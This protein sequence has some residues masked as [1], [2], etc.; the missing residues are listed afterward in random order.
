M[1][2]P[3]HLCNKTASNAL[4]LK[5]CFVGVK[6]AW[7]PVAANAAGIRSGKYFSRGE[8]MGWGCVGGCGSVS[9]FELRLH[10]DVCSVHMAQA[11]QSPHVNDTA[12]ARGLGNH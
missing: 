7:L 12:L 9:C 2:L 6:G 10:T 8:V 1:Q 3:Q 5:R 11:S 4:L